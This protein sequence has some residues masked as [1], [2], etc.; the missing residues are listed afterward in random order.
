MGE[1]RRES[2]RVRLRDI[3]PNTNRNANTPYREESINRLVQQIKLN[4]LNIKFLCR[5][6]D[7]KYELAF[8]HHRL[9]A[10]KRLWG[11]D[12]GLEI[13]VADLTDA[14]MI[15]Q[16]SGDNDPAYDCT[17]QVIDDAVR[18]AW[19]YLKEHP[20]EQRETLTSEG[21][22]D[23][24]ERVRLGAP[25]IANFLKKKKSVVQLSL[26]RVNAVDDGVVDDQALYLLPTP[27]AAD[28]FI[29]LLKSYSKIEKKDHVRLA[30]IINREKA[31]EAGHMQMAVSFH[32]FNRNLFLFRDHPYIYRTRIQAF[33][34]KIEGL[35]AELDM[36]RKNY[37]WEILEQKKNVVD[38]VSAKLL[39]QFRGRIRYLMSELKAT[40]EFLDQVVPKEAWKAVEQKPTIEQ[41]KA[42]LAELEK[43]SGTKILLYPAQ[44]RKHF[45]LHKQRRVEYRNYSLA[46]VKRMIKK[47]QF[48]YQRPSSR[49]RELTDKEKE[50]R[51]RGAKST[52]SGPS[53]EQLAAIRKKIDNMKAKFEQKYGEGGPGRKKRKGTPRQKR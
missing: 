40:E 10:A 42:K 45:G 26:E 14:D 3:V 31:Y 33:S 27:H 35:S 38:V 20:E 16:M 12:H 29:S 11:D 46:E 49:D 30:N 1:E 50:A 34:G 25:I 41:Y 23:K 6:K 13:S 24:F 4:G 32:G 53:T 17:M 8:G 21:S 47:G 48:F 28:N 43:K 2:V 51:R 19:N 22:E 39:Q 5:R 9:E 15:S 44:L 7:G 52:V 18:A 36:I 37:E